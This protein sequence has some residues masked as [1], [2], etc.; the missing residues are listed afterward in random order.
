[1]F[2]FAK[3]ALQPQVET[4]L[5]HVI[6]TTLLSTTH[7]LS[8]PLIPTGWVTEKIIHRNVNFYHSQVI[9]L[10]VILFFSL[11]LQ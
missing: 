3:L 8:L 4:T 1:M 11:F 2:Y 10:W 5:K 9:G 6:L 7:L